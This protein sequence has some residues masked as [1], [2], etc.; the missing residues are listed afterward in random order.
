MARYEPHCFWGPTG[1]EGAGVR[2]M[3]IGRTVVVVASCAVLGLSVSTLRPVNVAAAVNL[4]QNGGFELPD[5]GGSTCDF[6][7]PNGWTTAFGNVDLVGPDLWASKDGKQSVDLNGSVPGS[8]F[9]DLATTAGQSYIVDFWYAAN[10]YGDQATPKTFNVT[11]DGGPVAAVAFDQTGRTPTD[12]GWLRGTSTVT[13]TSAT[14]RLE[15]DS[16]TTAD[17]QHGPALDAV[18]VT[19][20]P[21]VSTPEASSAV[22][23]LG[24]GTVA[25]GSLAFHRRR[26]SAA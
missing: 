15:F 1:H 2:D 8:L 17:Q 25:A 3:P 20:A 13:A 14:S 5:C 12:M 9:Q 7:V 6:V 18:S 21:T 24:L 19:L 11:W 16:T 22:L 23:L 10:L 26:R 4:V